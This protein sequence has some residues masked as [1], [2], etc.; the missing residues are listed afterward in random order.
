MPSVLITGA[1]R[2]LGL[3]FASQYLR[4]GWSVHACCRTPETATGVDALRGDGDL[5][6]HRRM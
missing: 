3:E 1:S 6:V 5:T 4:D 2:G